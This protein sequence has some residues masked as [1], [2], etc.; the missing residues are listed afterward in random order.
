M[1][2]DSTRP[3]PRAEATAAKRRQAR[4]LK[5]ALG[6]R[7]R[8]LRQGRGI[9]QE[10]LA[11]EALI[12]RSYMGDIERGMRNPSLENLYAIATALGVT[13]GELFPREGQH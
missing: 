2:T 7:V 9:S 3:K 5:V 10:A 13:V 12:H 8:A 6:L 11:D 4:P 1:D